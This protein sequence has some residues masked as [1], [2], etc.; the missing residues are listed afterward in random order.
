M[1]DK[2]F[3]WEAVV[4]TGKAAQRIT[5]LRDLLRATMTPVKVELIDQG[6]L[7]QSVGAVKNATGQITEA[8]KRITI[9]ARASASERV[10]LA[11][12]ESALVAQAARAASTTKIEEE[13]RSTAVLKAELAERSRA[14]QAQARQQATASTPAGGGGGFNLGSAIKGGIAGYFTVQGIRQIAQTASEIARLDTTVSRSSKAFEIMSGSAAKAEKTLRAIQAASGGTVNNLEA[15]QIANQAMSLGLAKTTTDFEKLTRAARAVTFVSPVIH[16]VQS[17][18][19]E[20]ALAS[21]NLSFRR[22]DQ[23]GLSVTEVKSRMAE[24]QAANKGMDD[25]TAFLQAS[26]GALNEKFGGLLD[27]TEAQASGFEKLSASWSNFVQNVATSALGDAINAAFAS[28]IPMLDQLEKLT[29]GEYGGGAN[30]GKLEAQIAALKAD[31]AARQAGVVNLPG[32]IDAVQGATPLADRIADLERIN[33]LQATY[34]QLV[35]A[36]V[37][38]LDNYG[39]QL[40]AITDYA[41]TWGVITA[42]QGTQMAQ[43]QAQLNYAASALDSTTLAGQYYAQAVAQVGAD[44]LQANEK[45]AELVNR[46]AELTVME[47]TG[48]ISASEYAAAINT[49][50]GQLVGMATQANIATVALTDLN[51]QTAVFYA[52]QNSKLFYGSGGTQGTRPI[53]P[54]TRPQAVSLATDTTLNPYTLATKAESDQA[55]TDQLDAEAKA[56]AAAALKAA[57]AGTKAFNAAESAMKSLLDGIIKVSQVTQD[58]IDAAKEGTYQDK[59]DEYLRQLRDEVQNGKNYEDV[60]IEEAAAGLNKIGIETAGKSAEAVL[61][62]FEQAFGNLSLF[63]DESNLKF[64][65]EEAINLQIDLQ[66]KSKQGQANIYKHFGLSVDAAVAAITGGSGAAAS[67][68]TTG[69]TGAAGASLTVDPAALQALEVKATVTELTLAPGVDAEI[70]S[71]IKAIIKLNATSFTL[72]TDSAKI[73]SDNLAAAIAPTI[74][75]GAPGQGFQLLPADAER[76]RASL[77]LAITPKIDLNGFGVF[78]YTREGLL[79][80][81]TGLALV[82]TPTITPEIGVPNAEKIAAFNSAFTTALQQQSQTKK[83]ATTLGDI[84]TGGEQDNGLATM[85]Q[86]YIGD[87]TTAITKPESAL[88]LIGAGAQVRSIIDSGFLLQNETT[89]GTDFIVSL[90]NAIFAE[91]NI[92]PIQGIGATVYVIILAGIRN[93][94]KSKDNTIGQEIVNN[95]AA[96]VAEAQVGATNEV[97]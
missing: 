42:E 32:A 25:S 44:S 89:I 30:V 79:P 49:L 52:A 97:P 21:A 41:Q 90:Q 77:G 95:I 17:A 26:V 73:V 12:N 2:T 76:I 5:Q 64:L 71:K 54:V 78:D 70:S 66:E 22:L 24:L 33:S 53:G 93:A 19:T 48:A 3:T 27:S 87:I 50:G 8:E 40:N 91:T 60:S 62:L 13:K 7:N 4:D 56:S 28:A 15:I 34:N 86:K 88:Q 46:M 29:T 69:A 58:D 31:Q 82:L 39:N 80:I 74:D 96:Q 61:K 9:E 37:P 57:R 92:A 1:A 20:L 85:A 47:Q 23:L 83:T 55:R 36:G 84:G 10:A 94:M 51:Y 43:L 63:A 11:R 81:K 68:G 59:P 16:D 35:E 14:I 18:I 72:E 38:G 75:L 67:A 6:S 45:T 65:N